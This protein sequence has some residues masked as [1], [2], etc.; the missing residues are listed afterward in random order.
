MSETGHS[1]KIFSQNNPF[2]VFN[3]FKYDQRFV[4]KHVS[5]LKCQLS[6][7]ITEK[8][9]ND[10]YKWRPMC[11]TGHGMQ[12]KISKCSSY[13]IQQLQIW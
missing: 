3:N 8:W 1:M 13:H 9:L 11:N 5:E 12:T 2:D 7:R 6:S 4:K 10:V